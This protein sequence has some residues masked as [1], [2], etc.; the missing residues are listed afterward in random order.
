MSELAFTL[1]ADGRSDRMLLPVICWTLRQRL[2]HRE[3]RPQFPDFS[4]LP[5]PPKGLAEKIRKGL[6]MYPCDLLFIHRD[7]ERSSREE[8]L[9]EIQS[10]WNELHLDK[11]PWVAVIPVRMSEAWLL[12]DEEAIRR[13]AD[14][15]NGEAKLDLPS[16]KE[17]ESV[18]DP[19]RMLCELLRTASELT[20][21]RLAKFDEKSRIPRIGEYIED[22][23]LLRSLSAF[24]QLEADIDR[25]CIQQGW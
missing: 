16:S 11:P 1:I 13:A 10:A 19:K 18:P 9:E 2:L 5:A 17:W 8:R 3:L 7:A 15:P 4:R 21:R 23:G 24:K 14:N 12:F 25:V 22:F 6:A 20:G